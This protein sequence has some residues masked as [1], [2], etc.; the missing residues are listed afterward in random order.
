M[1][2][3]IYFIFLKKEQKAYNINVRIKKLDMSAV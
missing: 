2:A 1:K 3:S